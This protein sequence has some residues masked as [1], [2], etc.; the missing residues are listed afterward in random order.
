MC[1]WNNLIETS[2][3]LNLQE[4]PYMYLIASAKNLHQPHTLMKREKMCVLSREG[5]IKEKKISRF[6]SI[7]GLKKQIKTL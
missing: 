4:Y 7:Y 5:L 6:L 2:L 3:W 1:Y